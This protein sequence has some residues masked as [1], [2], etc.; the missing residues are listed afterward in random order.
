MNKNRTP[1]N[2][3][4]FFVTYFKNYPY[5]CES[6]I[7]SAKKQMEKEIR[8]AYLFLRE[9]N[10]KIPSE[11]LQ[12]ML[13]ASLEKLKGFEICTLVS[14]NLTHLGGRMGTEYTTTNYSKPFKSIQKAKEFA[15]KEYGNEL[16]WVVTDKGLRTEDLGYVMYYINTK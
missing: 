15:E 16:K 13:D 2:L 3:V 14:E 11:T 12:F 5:N 1:L 9:K 8:E 4:G 10:Q 6:I 7:M